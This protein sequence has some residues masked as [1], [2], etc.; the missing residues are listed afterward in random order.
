MQNLLKSHKLTQEQ[1]AK[2][3]MPLGGYSKEEVRL[4]AQKAGISVAG[5]HDSQ[6]LCFIVEGS[7]ADY[8]DAMKGIDIPKG[9]FVD[10]EGNIL[11]E[12]KG[13]HHYTIGQRKGLE[14]A[15]GSPR[16]VTK[17]DPDTNNIVLGEEEDLMKT[18][19][20]CT[21]LNFV[22]IASVEPGEKIRCR[23]K[24][25]YA[26]KA[27]DA[28]ISY[29]GKNLI[30]IDFDESV[31]AASPGQSAVFYDDENCVLGGGRIIEYTRA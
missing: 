16:Y 21:D 30:K 4:I 7:H 25:R 31:R 22:G 8:I 1:L 20:F 13:I 27:Q 5:K 11:G 28:Y 23:V 3:L 24:I 12:H 17:I 9:N 29:V 18:E 14:I 2:T 19:V 26:H 15:L 6:E 10:K